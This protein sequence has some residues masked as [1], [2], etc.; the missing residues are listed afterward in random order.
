MDNQTA[1]HKWAQAAAG[2]HAALLARWQVAKHAYC[3]VGNRKTGE[4]QE[5]AR[6]LA[7]AGADQPVNPDEKNHLQ[8]VY[9]LAR[10]YTVFL[11]LG[12]IDSQ[13]AR[14]YRRIYPYTRFETLANKMAE[15]EID[16]ERLF[17]YLD[18]EGGNRAMAAFIDN[19]E[20]PLPEWARRAGR[21][22]KQAEKLVTDLDVPTNVKQAAQYYIEVYKQW[23][24]TD[25]QPNMTNSAQL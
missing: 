21:I 2:D 19:A 11:A 9:R 23:I 6:A 12:A 7:A 22:T 10:A 4:A 14:K 18:I 16:P 20:H 15:Y 25:C 17:D 13:Q 3:I 5:L 8:T 24:T 1:A